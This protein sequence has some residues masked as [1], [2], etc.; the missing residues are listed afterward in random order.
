MRALL[1]PASLPHINKAFE[2]GARIG[3]WVADRVA[4]A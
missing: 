4:M 1:M 3:V 2:F